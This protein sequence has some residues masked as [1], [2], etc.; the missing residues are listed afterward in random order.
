LEQHGSSCQKEKS[1]I[2][3]A[4]G[5]V[6][7]NYSSRPYSLAASRLLL[8]LMYQVFLWSLFFEDIIAGWK[9][10]LDS[11]VN[12]RLIKINQRRLKGLR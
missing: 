2:S 6:K 5:M 10:K 4:K 7:E 12:K 3:L 11:Q 8:R 9:R 1:L